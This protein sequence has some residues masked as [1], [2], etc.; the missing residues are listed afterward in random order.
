MYFKVSLAIMGSV[1]L[2][3]CGGG[4]ADGG[5][6]SGNSGPTGTSALIDAGDANHLEIASTLAAT[7]TLGGTH[8]RT[9]GTVANITGDFTHNTGAVRFSDG[10]VILDDPDG[11]TRLT[12]LQDGS[13]SVS[14]FAGSGLTSDFQFL[15]P[16]TISS[17]AGSGSAILGIV[18]EPASMPSTASASYVG[19]S[20]L[21]VATGAGAFVMT[22][23][24]LTE[25]N[26]AGG[27]VDVEMTSF[28]SSSNPQPFDTLTINGMPISG[29][30]FSGGSLSTSLDGS[31]VN[32]LGSGSTTYASRGG[33]FGFDSVNGVPAEVG[34][35]FRA[36]GSSGEVITGL[37]TG[38]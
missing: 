27:W 13:A 2:V 16:A 25:A 35:G 29:S 5:Q 24:A 14:V 30:G 18:T 33:F 32:V 20:S 6:T 4:S 15:T 36:D 17:P 28:S 19:Q 9:D 38:D 26:F 23:T 1:F 21:N 11:G 7:S 12:G 37:F 34:G 22:G 10:S 8:V 31:T 3:N